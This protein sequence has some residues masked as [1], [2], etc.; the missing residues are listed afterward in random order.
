M[1]QNINKIKEL[2]QSYDGNTYAINRLESYINNLPNWIITDINN[3]EK[4]INRTTELSN[5][6]EIFCKIFLSKHK[7]FY[8]PSNNCFYEY[9]D[10][11]Y[12][13]IK[14]DNIHYQLLS[15]ITIEG[16]LLQW[17]YKTKTHIIKLIK[18]R[19]LFKSIPET[20]TI[21]TVLGFLQTTLF[22]TKNGAKY[23]LTILG[24]NILKKNSDFIFITTQNTK[25]ILNL[26]DDIGHAT[27]GSSIMNN[28]ITKHHESH[29]R[30][31]YRLIKTY[32]NQVSID[33]IKEMLNKIGIDLLCVATHYSHRYVNAEQY[34]SLSNKENETFKTHA[35]FLSNNT[36]EQ[37]VEN[38]VSQCLTEST[39]ETFIISWK[40]MHYIWK[41]Y[42]THLN[43][44]NMI[45]SNNLKEILKSRLQYNSINDLF[46]KVTSKYLPQISKFLHFW[47]QHITIS[48][49]WF[50]EYEI[51]ELLS[52]F[53]NIYG[54]NELITEDEML[55]I[56]KHFFSNTVTIIDN[57]FIT[58]I[59]CNLWNKCEDIHIFLHYYKHKSLSLL[60]NKKEENTIENEVLTEID[61]LI[62]ID[63]LYLHYQSYCNASMYVNKSQYMIVS[64]HY[65]EKYIV[66]E[67]KQ[68]IHF[69]KFIGVEWLQE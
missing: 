18:E 22:D 26:I 41:L 46:I 47:E 56:I 48:T 49:D 45:Y 3:Y 12:K 29:N 20:Y 7:Y 31:N 60:D 21:Q 69:E 5:E 40:N 19:N 65:F 68:F 37:I 67:L 2:F 39:D 15:T 16:K 64:K 24:D 34:L 28:F 54:S 63:D 32:E 25:K 43:I 8:L 55:K 27:T 1:E 66:S 14:D 59:K 42:L 57:K 6:Q 51:D 17:K 61:G 62:S 36:P 11:T 33:V 38:F 10:K 35:L 4:R 30:T 13:I 52:I 44:P 50:N 23:F 53:K 9:D 58:N